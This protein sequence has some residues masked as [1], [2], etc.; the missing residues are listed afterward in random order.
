MNKV[1]FPFEEQKYI[2]GQLLVA[3]PQIIDSRFARS[4]ILMCGHDAN[5]AMGIIIN[6]LI[7][8]LTF[9]DLLDQLS[10]PPA[11]DIY[12]D[13]PVHFGGP[14]E[15]GRGFVVHS[16]DYF[17]ET[18]IRVSQDIALSSTTEILNLLIEGKGPSH[19]ILVLGYAGWSAG[20]LETELQKNTWLQVEA[21]MDLVFSLDL[22]S[23]WK[24]A[25]RKIGVDPVLLSSQVGNA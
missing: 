16:T 14:I 11:K 8:D 17:H 7:D 13:T 3:S 6:Q 5:G 2:T 19:K 21:D 12:E 23:T 10:I 24:R 22:S 15:M 18:S 25:L 4:V 1:N 20:Q 9:K